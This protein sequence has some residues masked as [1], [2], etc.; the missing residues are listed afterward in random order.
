MHAGKG[1][2]RASEELGG[3]QDGTTNPIVQREQANARQPGIGGRC[4][5]NRGA[6]AAREGWVKGNDER[7]GDSE[8]NASILVLFNCS[9]SH[10]GTTKCEDCWHT[11]EGGAI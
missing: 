1:R 10:D 4:E 9:K 11:L 5:G 7:R 2:L 3:V 6:S 8:W